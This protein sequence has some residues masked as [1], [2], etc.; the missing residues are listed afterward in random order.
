M[1]KANTFLVVGDIHIKQKNL[2]RSELILSEIG[3]AILETKP[4][5]GTIILGDV[6]DNH[7]TVHLSCQRLY[8]EFIEH[9]SKPCLIH[10][11][12]NH[13]MVNSVEL[14]PQDH[15]L[16]PFKHHLLA[17]GQMGELPC[18][19]PI[20]QPRKLYFRQIDTFLG[21]I[22]FIPPKTDFSLSLASM[23]DL[24]LVFCHQEFEGAVFNAKAEKSQ[25]GDEVPDRYIISGHIHHNQ[26]LGKVWYP[27]TPAQNNF[28]E[29]ADKHIY[30]IEVHPTQ[31][32]PY[33]VV[34][35]ITLD[36]PKF[37][38]HRITIEQA[39]NDF[40]FVENDDS[41]RF[42]IEGTRSELLAFKSTEQFQT[43]CNQGK[44]KFVVKEEAKPEKDKKETKSFQE[45][46]KEYAAKENLT[47]V[48]STV[49]N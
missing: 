22:P 6:F 24:P 43:L 40:T 46:L 17:S 16:V 33:T 31:Q 11:L 19:I 7:G 18:Y 35:T 1:G 45:L 2:Q 32:P 20:T 39:R 15:A 34:E 21:F 38:T 8:T 13:E 27:G 37:I 4:G 41:K 14:L 9:Y 23:G 12:G 3:K 30:L 5:L 10:V 25:I 44:V 48:Y 42:I 26:T 47:D 36:I 29:N 49:F 28:G